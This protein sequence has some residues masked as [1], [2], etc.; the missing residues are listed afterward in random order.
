[1]L[2]NGPGTAD[3][4]TVGVGGT[5]AVVTIAF[6]SDGPAPATTGGLALGGAD[7]G[8]VG[9]VS[10]GCGSRTLPAYDECAVTVRLA[11]VRAGAQTAT[12]SL[13]SN[14]PASPATVTLT[15][16]ATAPAGGGNT[17]P[18]VNPSPLTPA[19]RAGALLG[20]S[21]PFAAGTAGNLRL[22]TKSRSTR[23]GKPKA[24]MVLGAAVCSGGSCSGKA[25][26]KLTLTP[27]TGKKRS[28][29]FTLVRSLRLADGGA[30]RLTLK[31]KRTDRR[32]IDAARKASLTLTVTNGRRS[33][34]RTFSLTT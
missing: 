19:Q 21:S 8:A 23:L 1:V 20:T 15:G 17:P 34:K 4:G 11:P 10:D 16:L 28:Y 26:A 9:I 30:T 18:V 29:S 25:T 3:L 24:S 12:L 27:R 31:L 7:A 2:V 13:P 14:D 32:R 33:V 22:Y 6:T 5:G